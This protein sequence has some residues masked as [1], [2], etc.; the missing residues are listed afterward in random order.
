MANRSTTAQHADR[1]T[2]ADMRR[3]LAALNMMT[4]GELAAKY[5]EVFGVPTRSRNGGYLRR[6][7]AWRIQEQQEGGLSPRAL[8]RIGLLAPQAPAR[9]HEGLAKRKRDTAR[10]EIVVRDPRLPPAGTVLTRIYDG[11]EHKV[12]V[13]DQGFEYR[14]KR[15]RS[16]SQIAKLI[17]HTPWNGFTFF[18]G[19]TA[20][21]QGSK[22]GGAP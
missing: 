1:T 4:I 8:E 22:T 14:G 11:A 6:H 21:A 2:L 12:K 9:W 19:R 15:Y 7:I 20:V 16:L 3:E 5:R 18:L 17:T 10:P 13:L